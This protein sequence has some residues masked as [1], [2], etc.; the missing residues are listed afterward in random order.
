MLDEKRS[1]DAGCFLKTFT[2]K[3]IYIVVW[4]LVGTKAW[5]ESS[6][7]CVGHI[8]IFFLREISI[9]IPFYALDT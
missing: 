7:I 6:L 2:H 4:M 5:E 1:L 8:I 3:F 9:V